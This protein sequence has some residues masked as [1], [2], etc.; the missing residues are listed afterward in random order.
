MVKSL[1]IICN[2]LIPQ[3]H[4]STLHTHTHSRLCIASQGPNKPPTFKALRYSPHCSGPD[5]PAAPVNA[6]PRRVTQTRHDCAL[7]PLLLASGIQG[8]GSPIYGGARPWNLARLSKAVAGSETAFWKTGE[9]DARKRGKRCQHCTKGFTKTHAAQPHS[10]AS[11]LPSV[12]TRWYQACTSGLQ[13]FALVKE[14]IRRVQGLR[15]PVPS[16]SDQVSNSDRSTPAR[17]SRGIRAAAILWYLLIFAL[18]K[19]GRAKT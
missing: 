4:V 8:S 14:I 3:L 17:R 11:T 10:P 1:T 7:R 16:R 13:A 9:S 5:E 2:A 18:S 19:T 15:F 6:V 12:G